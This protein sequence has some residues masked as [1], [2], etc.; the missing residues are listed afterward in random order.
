MSV[1]FEVLTV[2]VMR[3]SIFWVIMQCHLLKVVL[4]FRGG[5]LLYF[6][7]Q[8]I[9]QAGKKQS[10]ASCYLLADYLPVLLLKLK[11]VTCSSATSVDVQPITQHST[12]E[13]RTQWGN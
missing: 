1:R 13:D 12:S 2:V 11:M 7:C 10:S 9:S 8:R 6:R 3:S 5:C 4:Y